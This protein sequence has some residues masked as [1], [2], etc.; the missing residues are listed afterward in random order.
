MDL[1]NDIVWLCQSKQRLRILD[2]FRKPRIQAGI[3]RELGLNP[4]YDI[5]KNI[6]G[7]LTHGLIVCLNS[8]SNENPLYEP[9]QKGEERRKLLL[10]KNE[11]KKLGGLN[12]DSYVHVKKGKARTAIVLVLKG[13][14]TARIIGKNASLSESHTLDVL[15]DLIKEGVVVKTYDQE[16]EKKVYELTHEGML[17]QDILRY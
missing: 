3:K 15:K 8:G 1:T 2:A 7:F 14:M 6:Q 12:P 10:N 17:I 13:Q 4:N 9:T 5:S 16:I 11:V